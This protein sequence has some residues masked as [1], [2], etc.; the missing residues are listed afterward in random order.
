MLQ[1]F[2]LKVRPYLLSRAM[3]KTNAERQRECEKRK[4]SMKFQNTSQKMN[5]SKEKKI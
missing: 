5:S 1:F 2:I 3:T 4:K